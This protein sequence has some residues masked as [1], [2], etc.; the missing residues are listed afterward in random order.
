MQSFKENIDSNAEIEAIRVSPRENKK[1]NHRLCHEV[2]AEAW[3]ENEKECLSKETL[4]AA[5]K[6]TAVLKDSR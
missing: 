3:L 2:P 1:T 6:G 4:L 5:Q